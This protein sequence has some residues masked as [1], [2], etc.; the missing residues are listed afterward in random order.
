MTV[1]SPLNLRTRSIHQT[2]AIEC[3]RKKKLLPSDRRGENT[4]FL[5]LVNENSKVHKIDN[6]T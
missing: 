2:Y 5:I 1:R 6:E 4:S 3:G